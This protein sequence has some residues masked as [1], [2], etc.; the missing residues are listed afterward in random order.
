MASLDDKMATDGPE[1]DKEQEFATGPLSVL[2][3]SVKN[4]TQ[5]RPGPALPRRVAA[6]AS[7]ARPRARPT[8]LLV[9]GAGPRLELW[10]VLTVVSARV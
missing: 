7:A 8:L 10:F 6:A 3:H 5:V 4:N 1:G 9:G 2:M